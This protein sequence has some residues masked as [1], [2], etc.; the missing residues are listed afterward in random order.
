MTH[1]YICILKDSEIS[2]WGLSG[3]ERLIRMIE[4]HDNVELVDRTSQVPENAP[5]L[6]LRGDYLFESRVLK[7]LIG[8]DEDVAVSASNS[9]QI[10]A[11]RA[12]SSNLEVL[13]QELLGESDKKIITMIRG[14]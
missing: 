14:F 9:D 12:S 3:K 10:V 13:S 2:L 5:V 7:E 4:S 8:R 1:T 6:L 11:A